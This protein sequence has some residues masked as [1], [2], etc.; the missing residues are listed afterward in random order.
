M[1]P[2]VNPAPQQAPP[3]DNSANA[4]VPPDANAAQLGE[5]EHQIDQASGRAA[6]VKSSLDAMKEA[7]SRQGLGLR[8]DIVAS[9]ARMNN[10]LAK[11]DSALQAGDTARA[12][13]YL[14]QAETE[15]STI[16]RFLGR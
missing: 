9:E 11:A 1:R 3:P 5:L 7:M 16:E 8:G 10:D 15:I 2:R 12:K 14:D 4:P 13:T 6:A